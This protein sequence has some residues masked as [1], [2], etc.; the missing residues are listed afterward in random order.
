MD[1]VIDDI[2]D[3]VEEDNQSVVVLPGASPG[4]SV[5]A[6]PAN[7]LMSAILGLA[8]NSDFDVEKLKALIGLQTSQEDRQAER[9]F[10]QSFVRL[11]SK[12]PVVKRKGTLEYPVNKNDPEGAKRKIS[13]YA[14]WEDIHKAITPIL[15]GEG[16]AL[17]F[18]VS[19]RQG[20]GGGLLVSAVLR[21]EGGHC[22]T[23]DPI[24][25]PLDTS[26]GKNNVQAY[27][28]ALSYG[29]RYATYAVL[30]INTEGEDD[31]GV[32]A[33]FKRL[34]DEQVEQLSKLVEETNTDPRAFF[35]TM[36][37]GAVDTFYDIDA[38]EFPRL[39]NA[40]ISKKRKVAKDAA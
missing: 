13:D 40:L 19:P 25:V 2:E 10:N 34:S 11:Q 24:P 3:V 22:L 39:M 35:L 15:A 33:G 6:Q 16:F 21:H 17:S 27:G 30:N 5:A 26:G 32:A 38:K 1:K 20:D 29:K 14:R 23:G 28:S 12:L 36:I 8:A 4:A 37:T 31:D 9:A 7:E 18:K